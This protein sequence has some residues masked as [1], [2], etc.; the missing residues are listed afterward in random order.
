MFS[1][2][3]AIPGLSGFTIYVNFAH[4]GSDGSVVGSEI[5]NQFGGEGEK[6]DCEPGIDIVS[7]EV[8][9]QVRKSSADGIDFILHG[10]GYIDHEDEISGGI[11][12]A[13]VSVNNTRRWVCCW[14]ANDRLRQSSKEQTAKQ[15]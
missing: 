8:V 11:T 5:Q 7:G 2:E 9:G 3:S 1:L 4:G 12:A 10:C 6:D 15:R 13:A 14:V